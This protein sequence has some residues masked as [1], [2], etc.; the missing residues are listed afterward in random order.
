MIFIINFLCISSGYM[1]NN[2]RLFY[3]TLS[4]VY[5]MYICLGVMEEYMFYHRVIA[6]KVYGEIEYC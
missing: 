6:P 5:T 3:V 1:N 2:F 4:S